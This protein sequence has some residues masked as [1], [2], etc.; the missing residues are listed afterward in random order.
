MGSPQGSD[1]LACL[2]VMVEKSGDPLMYRAQDCNLAGTHQL[3][4][5]PGGCPSNYYLHEGLCYQVLSPDTPFTDLTE[6][7]SACLTKGSTLAYPE[8][9]ARITY[10]EGLLR[11]Q[12]NFGESGTAV[13]GLNDKYVMQVRK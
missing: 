8:T 6:A 1:T 5:L 12:D 13:L 4:G 7:L 3:C 9:L 2:A 11:M 10:L